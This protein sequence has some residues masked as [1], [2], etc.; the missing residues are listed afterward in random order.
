MSTPSEHRIRLIDAQ[1][2]E[3]AAQSI[4]RAPL[5]DSGQTWE[6]IIHPYED[7]RNLEQNAKMW[8]CIGDIKQQVVWH[9]R[10]LDKESWKQMFVAALKGQDV[11]PGINGGFVVIGGSS[12]KLP[13]RDFI[14]LIDLIQAFGVEHEVTW[15]EKARAVFDEM[16]HARAT[17]P[18][19]AAS[20]SGG[21]R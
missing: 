18:A 14:D 19:I 10:Y 17:R 4:L 1:R 5:P 6:V 9:G 2:R 15:S 20:R 3:R 11:V 16:A 7:T 21:T 12:R 8:A 13:K